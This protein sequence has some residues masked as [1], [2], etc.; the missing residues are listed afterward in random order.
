MEYVRCDFCDSDDTKTW[1]RNSA[2]NVVKCTNCGL[3]YSNPRLTSEELSEFYKN[4][5]FK[6]G[7]NYTE[8][9]IRFRQYLVDIRD[10]I[11]VCKPPGRI[12]DIGCAIGF[13][14]DNLPD[15]WEKYGIDSSKEAVEYGKGKYNLKLFEGYLP[16]TNLFEPDFFDVIHMRATL[17]H[18]ESPKIYLR[19]IFELLRPG[20]ILV[21]SNLPNLNSL[22]AKIYKSNFRLLLPRQHLYHFTPETIRNYLHMFEFEIQRIYYPYIETPYAN[23]FKDL[24]A[25]FFNKFTSRK[26]PP[27]FRNVMTIYAQKKT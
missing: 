13:F 22:A 16:R 10:F 6:E 25:L 17:E 7:G 26:S 19:R 8:D 14:L 4:E 15:E 11:K 20:G 9:P 3:M 24:F 27:F 1:A 23:I 2:I 12:L 5:Y 21:I 18:V